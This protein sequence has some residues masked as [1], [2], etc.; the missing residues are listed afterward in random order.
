MASLFLTVILALVRMMIVTKKDDSWLQR[1]T[2]SC[3]NRLL[4]LTLWIFTLGF[5]LPPLIGIGRYDQSMVG[6]R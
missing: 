1:S 3:K 5:S 6:V 4:M 2:F